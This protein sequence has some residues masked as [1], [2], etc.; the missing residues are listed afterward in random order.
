VDRVRLEV[1]RQR[2]A[3]ARACAVVSTAAREARKAREQHAQGKESAHG[4]EQYG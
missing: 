2:A 3:L 1:E 4:G